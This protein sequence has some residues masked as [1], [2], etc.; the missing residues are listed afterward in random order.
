MTQFNVSYTHSQ[1][2]QPFGIKYDVCSGVHVVFYKLLDYFLSKHISCVDPQSFVRGGPTWTTCFFVRFFFWGGGGWGGWSGK[3]YH[4][5]RAI[6][7]PPAKCHLN[8]VSLACQ[9]WPNIECWLGSFVIFQSIRTSIDKKPY[10][11]VIFQG[12]RT[13]CLPPPLLWI[14]ACIF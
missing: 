12:V 11:F 2:F 9:W 4:F 1:L 10:T 3:R 14:C 8:G 5:K 6:I 7:G 13:P